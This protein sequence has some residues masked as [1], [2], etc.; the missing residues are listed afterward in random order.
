MKETVLCVILAALIITGLSLLKSE[1][2]PLDCPSFEV[3]NQEILAQ[4]RY[5]GYTQAYADIITEAGHI[6]KFNP[7]YVAPPS[8]PTF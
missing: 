7:K 1:P 2:L 4:E 3:V 6:Q 8:K 5:A